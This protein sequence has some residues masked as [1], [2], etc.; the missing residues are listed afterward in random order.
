MLTVPH[1]V[2]RHGLGT[3]KD[4]IGQQHVVEAIQKNVSFSAPS[5]CPACCE[6]LAVNLQ[7]R[8]AV[9]I[10]V[11]LLQHPRQQEQIRQETMRSV[12]GSALPARMAL[13]R[14]IL[15]R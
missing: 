5:S 14:Q 12:Y 7:A 10:Y 9:V 6:A 8:R 2:F 15:G 4:D 13:E 1:D 11:V 3:L